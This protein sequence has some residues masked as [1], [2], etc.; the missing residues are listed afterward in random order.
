MVI[1]SNGEHRYGSI[2]VADS[3]GLITEDF[4]E[5]SEHTRIA[6]KQDLLLAVTGATIGKV[7]II[8][9][10]DELAHSGDLLALITKGE[11]A[12]YYL[13]TVMESPIGQNQYPRWIMGSTNGHLAPTDLA[14][15]AIP[16]LDVLVEEKIANTVRESLNAKRESE[17]LLEQAKGRVEVL[18]AEA[19]KL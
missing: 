15:F 4:C 10:Y 11:I 5:F 6:N 17:E 9:R 14:R 18:I 2:K 7:G 12:P 13:L 19:V 3:I 8:E 1:S 16:I